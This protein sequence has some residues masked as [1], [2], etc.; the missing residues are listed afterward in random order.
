[1][2]KK[3][4]DFKPL[5]LTSFGISRIIAR[6]IVF[7][8]DIFITTESLTKGKTIDNAEY[9]HMFHNLIHFLQRTSCEIYLPKKLS[10]IK[11]HS[12]PCLIV[13]FNLLDLLGNITA[14]YSDIFRDLSKIRSSSSGLEKSSNCRP[15]HFLKVLN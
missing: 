2:V 5:F 13:E 11:F 1:M 8:Y 4:Y 15:Q 10:S 9:A 12:P 14:P 7:L 3:E 6:S